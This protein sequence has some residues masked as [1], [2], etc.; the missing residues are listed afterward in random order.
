MG[1]VR[2]RGSFSRAYDR[3]TR[4]TTTCLREF[5]SRNMRRATFL[6][7]VNERL[8]DLADYGRRSDGRKRRRLCT[9]KPVPPSVAASEKARLQI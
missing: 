5:E 3:K 1:G 9:I 6:G 2:M 4:D 8:G 7:R